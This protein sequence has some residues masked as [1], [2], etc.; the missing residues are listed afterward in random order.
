M[1]VTLT[2][3]VR[4]EWIIFCEIEFM[5]CLWALKRLSEKGSVYA[6]AQISTP[7]A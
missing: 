4:T 2:W 3:L 7:E 6:T 1:L 5:S